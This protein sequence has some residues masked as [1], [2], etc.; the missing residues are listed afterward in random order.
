V[1]GPNVQLRGRTRIGEGCRL[2][3]TAYLVD[4]TLGDRVHLLFGCVA[5]GAEIGHEARI[6]PFARL[7]PGTR[8]AERVHIGNFVETKQAVL[9]AGTKAN[10]LT[11][12]GDC[13]IGPDTNVGAG[14]ITCNYDGFKKHRTRIGAR[15]QIGSDTQLVAPVSVGDD[16]YVGAG[17]TVTRDVPPGALVLSRVPQQQVGG[18]VARKRALAA[19]PPVEA[20]AKAA[21]GR[22]PRREPKATPGR[23]PQRKPKAAPARA[24]RRR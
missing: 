16:A 13:V 10:H 12:L 2:D 19:R 4:T 8:L 3:G 20:V 18:W 7:R 11:Y 5:D 23:A 22:A 17:T 14:T 6:G 1:I 21:P 15:V 24:R 9:G